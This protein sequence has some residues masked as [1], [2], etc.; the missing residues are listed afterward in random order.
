MLTE[1]EIIRRKKLSTLKEL[2]VDPFGKAFKRTHLTNDIKKK[3]SRYDH[4]EL[5]KLNQ[6]VIILEE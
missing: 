3:F 4:D 1:Q 2:G 5:E 6:H